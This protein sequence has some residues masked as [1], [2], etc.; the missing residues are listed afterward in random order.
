[1]AAARVCVSPFGYG[2]VCF[3]D[4]EAVVAGC[5]LVKPDMSHLETTPNIYRPFQTYIPVRWDFADL[6]ATVEQWL[7]DEPRR[8]EIT[9]N[10]R[11]LF[12][13]DSDGSAIVD[14]LRTQMQCVGVQ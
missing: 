10:A 13:S 5:L 9:G 6:A 3:R 11:R 14:H 12:D 8:R 7:A 4:F 1:M 2:E